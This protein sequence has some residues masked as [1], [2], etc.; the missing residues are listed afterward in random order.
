MEERNLKAQSA[1]TG[2]MWT[3]GFGSIGVGIKNNLLG[4][5]LLFYYNAVL[6]LEAWLVTIAIGIAL[7]IDAIS[8]PFVGVWSDRVRTKWGRRH[9]FMYGAVIPF[10]LCYYLILQDPGDISDSALFT[11]LLVLMILMRLAM[12][13]YEV[14]RGA[15]APELTKDYDQRNIIAGIGMALG[16][17]GG[18]GISFI[19][20]EYFLVDSFSNGAGYQLLAFW[21]GLGI[22]IS[23]VITT[24]G[25]H[26]RIPYLYVPPARSFKIRTFF[27]EAKET[28]SNRSW[29]VLFASGCVYALV[30]GTDTGAGTY[31]NTY[32]WEWKPNQISSFAAF[33]AISVVFIALFA[34]RIAIG[35][36]KKKIAVGIFLTSIVVGPL[37]MVLKLLEPIVGTPLLPS[38]GTDL[39]WW[40]LL[41]H[42]CALVSIGSLGFIFISSMAM[43]IVEDVEKTT[44]RREEGLLGTVSSMIQKLIGAGGVLIAGLIITWAGFD[45]PGVTEEM[46]SG[47]I[48]NRFAAAHVAIG[49][50]LPIISTLLILKYDIDRKDHLDNVNDLGYVEKS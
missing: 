27:G 38:N 42:S 6:G 40:I 1:S 22:F 44:G 25:T 39:L 16:W 3:Y 46:K 11:R 24:I 33:Q 34:P 12:T 50:F 19:H 36:S 45:N 14:P 2:T 4:T 31:Y 5:W 47:E 48:I 17:V 49:F 43:E 41:I 37:P 10:A 28:L 7:M 20:M 8:D 29:I 9:P 26:S 21:G 18:A 35:R 13:F 23:T 30:V 15:L 32:F